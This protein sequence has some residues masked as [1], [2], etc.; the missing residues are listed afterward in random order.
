MTDEKNI[1]EHLEEKIE[2][3]LTDARYSA[4]TYFHSQFNTDSKSLYDLEK[5]EDW[6]KVLNNCV[7]CPSSPFPIKSFKHFPI[8]SL[9]S[10][11]AF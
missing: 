4:E 2:T 8:S 11:I 6:V 10:S 7:T 3:I 9:N 5:K 1:E